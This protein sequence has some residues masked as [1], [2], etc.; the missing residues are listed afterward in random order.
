MV[1]ILMSY[2]IKIGDS[3]QVA[4][5]KYSGTLNPVFSGQMRNKKIRSLFF[6]KKGYLVIVLT[7]VPA[8]LY[9]YAVSPVSFHISRG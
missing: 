8:A 3:R 7:S 5:L 2:A 6:K 1:E 9:R 4:R